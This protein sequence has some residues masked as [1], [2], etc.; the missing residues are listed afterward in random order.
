MYFINFSV[1]SLALVLPVHANSD[2]VS[3]YRY[4][5]DVE[6]SE[7]VLLNLLQNVNG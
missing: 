5:I 6:V 2:D 3:D 1:A 7:I 4:I